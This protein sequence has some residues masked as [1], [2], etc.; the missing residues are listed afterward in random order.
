MDRAAVLDVVS[1]Y[2][3]EWGKP[4][5]SLNHS[6]AQSALIV[7]LSRKYGDEYT[8]L[9][10]LTL[11]MYPAATPDVA[12]YPRLS[13][14]WLRDEI[15]KTQ[16]PLLVVEIISPS[17]SVDELIPKIERYFEMG[18]RSCWLVQPPLQQIAVF[19]PEMQPEV[20]TRGPVQDPA[21]GFSVNIED[22]F[23]G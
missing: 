22:I 10:E 16:P 14:N 11:E 20:F 1:E 23:K 4:M 12:I 2:E 21:S 5:P 17:Q 18:V 7:E 3:Q 19:T 6:L 13:P 9:S 15:R 8:I